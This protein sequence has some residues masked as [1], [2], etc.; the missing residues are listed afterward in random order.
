MMNTPIGHSNAVTI[1]KYRIA[2][3]KVESNPIIEH[4]C[5]NPIP[6]VNEK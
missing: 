3:L 2:L 4:F 5:V 1:V 6:N